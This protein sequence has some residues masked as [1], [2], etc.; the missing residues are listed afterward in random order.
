MQPRYIF[1]AILQL[2]ARIEDAFIS[3]VHGFN[4]SAALIK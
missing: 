1:R 4:L 3:H 2:E